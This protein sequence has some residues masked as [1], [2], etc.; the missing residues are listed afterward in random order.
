MILP[1]HFFAP[2]LSQDLGFHQLYFT[3]INTYTDG[4]LGFTF[5]VTFSLTSSSSIAAIFCKKNPIPNMRNNDI[6]MVKQVTLSYLQYQKNMRNNDIT[7]VK[8]VTLSYLQYQKNMRNNDITIVKQVT[9]SYLQYLKNMRN[10]DITI[11]DGNR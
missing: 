2:V 6:T 7:I 3:V 5:L 11:S 8:Q 9:L 4:G 10:N 1:C